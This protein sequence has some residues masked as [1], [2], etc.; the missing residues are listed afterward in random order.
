MPTTKHS[1]RLLGS[2]IALFFAL[3][4]ATS[5]HAMDVILA[6][7]ANTEPDLAGYVIYYD[8][9][10]GEPY[11]GTG[12]LD[13]PSPIDVPLSSDEDPDPDVVQFTLRGLPEGDYYFAVTAYNNELLESSFSNEAATESASVAGGTAEGVSAGGGGGGGCFIGTAGMIN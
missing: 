10:S 12:S 1:A 13:G 3:T 4:T 6:W 8:T 7:D 11:E 9:D 5:S 2:L